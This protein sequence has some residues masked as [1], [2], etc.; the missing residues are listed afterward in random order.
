MIKQVGN[1]M[2]KYKINKK[3]NEKYIKISKKV[4]EK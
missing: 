3:Y 4:N 1:I 2:K